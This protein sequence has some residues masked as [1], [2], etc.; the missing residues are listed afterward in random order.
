MKESQ[1]NIYLDSRD[2]KRYLF[3]ALTCA[4]AELDSQSTEFIDLINSEYDPHLKDNEMFA[5]MKEAGFIVPEDVDELG[6]VKYRYLSNKYSSSD[7]NLTIAPTLECN[8]ACVYCYETP[9]VGMMKN[10]ITESIIEF[11]RS[12]LEKG[13]K[14]LNVTWYGGEPLL[15]INLIN[16]ISDKFIKLCDS[17]GAGYSAAI[18]SNGLLIDQAKIDLLSTCKVNMIQ[19]TVDGPEAIHNQRR[20][21]KFS[22]RGTFNT[23]VENLH[24]LKNSAISV[25]VRINIDMENLGYVVQLLEF[26]K[27]EGFESFSISFGHVSPISEVCSSISGRCFDREN[28]ANY[29]YLL[30]V[31][32]DKLG[33]FMLDQMYPFP[34]GVFCGADHINSFVIDPEGYMYKCWNEIGIKSESIGTVEGFA[35]LNEEFLPKILNLINYEPFNDPKCRQCKQLPICMGGCPQPRKNSNQGECE[36]WMFNLNK[37]LNFVISKE[38]RIGHA[39]NY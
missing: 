21:L 2:G 35:S 34:K 11:V 16:S 28:Y 26:F 25:V 22:G 23:I 4:F 24:A 36:Q 17:F 39:F 37:I 6:V 33:F 5:K 3:N 9:I 7:L 30:S 18:I 8:F 14:K 19:V 15:A 27:L 32:A 38:R 1:Y 10:K 13:T 20:G 29:N 31:E 12:R